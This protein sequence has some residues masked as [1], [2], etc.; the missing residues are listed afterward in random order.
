LIFFFF[1][2]TSF[3]PPWPFHPFQFLSIVLANPLLCSDSFFVFLA[4]NL[5]SWRLTFERNLKPSLALFHCIS[6]IS[7]SC[8]L[9]SP[10]FFMF[11]PVT[12]FSCVRCLFDYPSFFLSLCFPLLFFDFFSV[13]VFVLFFF[14]S[15]YT[16]FLMCCFLERCLGSLLFARGLALSENVLA[17]FK[18]FLWV[19]FGS[20]FDDDDGWVFFTPPVSCIFRMVF[21]LKSFVSCPPPPLP[22]S[23]R[24]S[25]FF[26]SLPY[27]SF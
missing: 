21:F 13:L 8:V 12:C 24:C 3:L 20:G 10:C 26:F 27:L 15:L 14:F 18:S 11:V 19:V 4:L 25:P 1:A 17:L 2:V 5:S 7:V 9:H 22:E 16:L 23:L 6:V